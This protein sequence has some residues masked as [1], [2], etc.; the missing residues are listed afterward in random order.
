MVL[1][2]EITKGGRRMA[3]QSGAQRSRRA[4]D[5]IVDR[6][7][8]M[9][10]TL[11]LAPG[12]V[13]TEAYLCGLLGCSRTPLREALQTLA[14]DRLVV[15][16]PQRGV[17]IAELSVIDY[18]HILEATL[19]VDSQVVRLAAERIDAERL[20]RLDEILVASA[21]ALASGDRMG[22][23]DADWELHR[24]IAE[25]TGNPFLVDVSASLHRLAARFVYYVFGRA[26][27]AESGALDDHRVIVDALRAHDAD[28]AEQ[29]AVDHYRNA[30]NRMRAAL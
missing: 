24:E 16:T 2:Q 21:T 10:V 18:G 4:S 30:R 13:V 6:L 20:A 11:E 17:S 5:D 3:T 19:A 12:S 9:I 29:A 14:A 1:G 23:A 7:R 28:G 22:S 27:D 15:A 26:N 25:A 8:T